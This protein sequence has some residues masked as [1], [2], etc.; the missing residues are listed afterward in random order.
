MG[1]ACQQNAYSS[2]HLVLSN[3]C[4]ACVLVLRPVYSEL[5]MFSDFEL[6]TTFGT[7]IFADLIKRKI[8][9]K[10]NKANLH[11]R[12]HIWGGWL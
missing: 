7:S 8:L 6:R 10:F 9:S 12:D 11:F 2:E 3:M 1:D 5:V 4:I